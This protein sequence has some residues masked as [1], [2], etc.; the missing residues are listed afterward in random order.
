MPLLLVINCSQQ[1]L[2]KGFFN[3][4]LIE[5]LKVLKPVVFFNDGV[6]RLPKKTLEKISH[7]IL[8]GSHFQYSKE[9]VPGLVTTN[10]KKCMQTLLPIFGICFGMQSMCYIHG[11]KIGVFQGHDE[12]K[13][14][15]A[16]FV[17]S[18]FDLLSKQL[19]SSS[20]LKSRHYDR[21]ILCPFKIVGLAAIG[22]QTHICAMQDSM[23]KWYGV[24][25]HPE[26]TNLGKEML[27]DF[28]GL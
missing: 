7:I 6:Q 17:F 12:N 15:N 2:S 10:I 28:L 27:L 11:G 24:Q 21:V 19:V 16:E 22:D 3:I 1:D 13:F 5:F 26:A 25:F 8:S 9:N 14:K 18:G 4:E 20:E 23:Q